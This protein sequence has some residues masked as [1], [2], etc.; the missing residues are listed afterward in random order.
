LTR[1]EVGGATEL[2]GTVGY[3]HYGVIGGMRVTGLK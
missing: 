3:A 1:A 2:R